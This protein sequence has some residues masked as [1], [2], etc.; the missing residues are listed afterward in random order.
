M[1]FQISKSTWTTGLIIFFISSLMVM[2][3]I[4][5]WTTDQK[6]WSQMTHFQWIFLPLLLVLGTLRWFLD[7]MAFVTMAKRGGHSGIQCK[8]AA[9]IRLEGSLVAAVVP[10]LVGTFSMHTY[11][12]HKEKL[13]LSESMAI[14]VV[15]AI[16]PILIFL[17]NIP[18]LI[19]M[20]T[21][22]SSGQ[23]FAQFMKM[24]SLPVVIIIAFLVIT[25]FYPH[26]IKNSASSVVRW[27]SKIKFIHISRIIEIEM[28]LFHE[29]EQ[30]SE[31]FRTYLKEKKRMLVRTAG[32]ILSAFIT[33]YLVAFCIIWG[34]GYHP[35][36]VKG[37]AIQ[38][39][40]RPIIYF[41]PTP[42][43]A[44]IWEATYLGFFS[45][46]MPRHLIG[47]AVLLWRLILTYF[48]SIAGILFLTREFHRDK[49]LRKLWIEKRSLP[50]QN[51][52]NRDDTSSKCAVA[53][54]ETCKRGNH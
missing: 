25:L 28:K 26:T 4:L 52:E 11:L 13:T 33:D 15:R 38:C 30:F 36:I 54:I 32:W 37:L 21:D 48:P 47:I 40:M 12:L 5:L 41:A 39:L 51:T 53:S 44:G 6:T 1:V 27:W 49:N 43:G 3:G 16:L 10:V 22:P 9:V 29:I 23:F 18:I 50:N 8:R 17:F 24:I 31:I 20:K 34:F 42:G 14:T 7:G 19:F 46:F 45:L 35:L 2:G